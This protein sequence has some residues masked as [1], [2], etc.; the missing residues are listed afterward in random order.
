MITHRAI[1]LLLLASA[2]LAGCAGPRYLTAYRYEPPLDAAGLACLEQCTQKMSACQQTCGE[3]AQACLQGIEPEVE[4]RHG[5]ALKNYENELARYR[6]ELE[7]YNLNLYWGRTPWFGPRHRFMWPGFY[8][9]FPPFPPE[10]PSRDKAFNQLRQEKCTIDCGCQ[11]IYDSCFLACGGKRIP[12]AK[13]IAN[14]P[15]EK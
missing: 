6:W 7:S 3:K 12:D 13:C 10:T 2:G 5:E 15:G 14:C 1:M 11:P 4:K 9:Y 8:Y